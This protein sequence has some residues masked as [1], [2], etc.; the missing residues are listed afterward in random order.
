MANLGFLALV[1][2]LIIAL[3]ALITQIYSIYS[4]NKRSQE[5]VKAGM[6][7]IAIVVSV[8]SVALIYLLVTNDFSVNYVYRNTSLSLSLLYKISAFWAGTSGSLLLWTLILAIFSAIVAHSKREQN[9]KLLPYV[10]I[11]LLLNI[12]FFSFALITSANPFAPT[13]MAVMDGTSLNP[14]LQTPLMIIHPIAVFLGYVGF[15][16][17][18]AFVIAALIIKDTEGLWIKSA[19]NWALLAWLFLSL[20]NIYGAQWAY[21]ELGWGGF[22]AWDPVENASFIPWLTATA[23]VH[24]IIIQERKGMFKIWS[25]ALIIVTYCLTIFGTYVVRSGVL[26]SVHAFQSSPQGNL[27]LVFLLLMLFV[28]IGLL[29][30]RATIFKVER[31]FDSYLSKEGSF[32]LNNLFLVS[33][34]F[35]IIL[36]TMLPIISKVFGGDAIT[37]GPDFYNQVVGPILYVTLFL[38]GICVTL[39]WQKSSFKILVRNVAG[40]FIIALLVAAGIYVIR[41]DGL[42]WQPILLGVATF[43]GL[44]HLKELVNGTL[45]GKREHGESLADSIKRLVLKHRR[46]FGGYVVHIGIILMAVAIVGTIGY[47]EEIVKTVSIGETIE[48]GDYTLTYEGLQEKNFANKTIVFADMPVLKNGKVIGKVDPGMVFHR[49]FSQPTAEV[50]ILGSLKEDLYVI[51]SAWSA[52]ASDVTIKVDIN[53]LMIWMWIGGYVLVAGTLFVAWPAR[54]SRIGSR[55]K[56]LKK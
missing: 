20:G 52:G 53:P 25:M 14:I 50:S 16:V 6:A 5:R 24:S 31:E 28:S 26:V 45:V 37:V 22:W 49:E 13:P 3:Y 18:F 29:V 8:A 19:R 46:R 33:A 4:G 32:L 17:P 9:V 21:T 10:N 43:T 34:A 42:Y 11:V 35:V 41:G 54:G 38:M 40:P 1:L 36:G 7:A 47:Q 55:N 48:I 39:A 30:W 44:V 51:L 56:L 27:F 15:V 2:T 12:A 23:F